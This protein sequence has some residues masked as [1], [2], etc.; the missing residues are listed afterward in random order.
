M[1]R[2]AALSA[3]VFALSNVV[4]ASELLRGNVGH[5]HP[6]AL[7]TPQTRR[8]RGLQYQAPQKTQGRCDSLFGYFLPSSFVPLYF[9]DCSTFQAYAPVQA[10]TSGYE[11]AQ[12]QYSGYKPARAQATGYEPAQARTSEY[13]S[14]KAK[15]S[16]YEPLVEPQE[17]ESEYD[18]ES[19]PYAHNEHQ[20]GKYYDDD[21]SIVNDNGK[22]VV[23][24]NTRS[25]IF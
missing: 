13:E 21:R 7:G 4:A 18:P 24:W 3:V 16:E 1:P 19:L 9:F 10:Q 5:I 6:Q 8:G 2:R 15:S 22:I 17:N 12:A 14:A 23:G 25:P 20:S 11:P